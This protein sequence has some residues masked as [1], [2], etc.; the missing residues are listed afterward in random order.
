MSLIKVTKAIRIDNE[1][2]DK[3][4]EASSL[5][6]NLVEELEEIAREDD[7]Y[8]DLCEYALSSNA[9]IETFLDAYMKRNQ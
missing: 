1:V 9:Y 5:M 4:E 6:K 3:I 7:F 8:S 2:L